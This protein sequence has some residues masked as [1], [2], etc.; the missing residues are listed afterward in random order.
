MPPRESSSV[1]VDAL[2]SP[3]LLREAVIVMEDML[4]NVLLDNVVDVGV[5]MVVVDTCVV[6][7]GVTEVVMVVSSY[8][9][10]SATTTLLLPCG[11][12]ITE[13]TWSR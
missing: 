9:C 11:R 8:S 2:V 1:L 13:E 4:D 3:V 12:P 10:T 5:L 7:R 6:V